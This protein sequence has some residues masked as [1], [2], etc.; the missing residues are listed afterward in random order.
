M[1]KG[2]ASKLAIKINQ[3]KQFLCLGL[4]LHVGDLPSWLQKEISQKGQRTAFFEIFSKVIE[5]ASK[6][7]PAIKFQMAFFEALGVVGFSLLEELIFFAKK[8]D[9]IV[10]L[11]GKRGDISS[12]M[13]AYAKMA[14]D[15]F[16]AD[17]VTVSPYLGADVLTALVPWL[18]KGRGAYVVY[19][20]SNSSGFSVQKDKTMAKVSIADRFF[21]ECIKDLDPKLSK[22]AVGIVVGSSSLFASLARDYRALASNFFLIPGVGEQGGSF[23]TDSRGYFDNTKPHLI[24]ISRSLL[25]LGAKKDQTILES[26]GSCD[27][28]YDFFSRRLRETRQMS[29]C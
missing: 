29:V 23:S 27:D 18:E 9:M 10:I 4:D 5:I 26:M 15:V 17:A 8:K 22:E 16:A 11:D 6:S 28:Y 2:Y 12:T 19:L 7:I 13:S 3:H 21:Y 25:A 24:T 14:F 20:S 1:Y